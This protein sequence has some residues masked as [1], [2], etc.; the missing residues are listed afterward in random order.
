MLPRDLKTNDDRGDLHQKADMSVK[1]ERW[2][3][4][5]GTVSE[6]LVEIT[7]TLVFEI[8]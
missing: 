5:V 3:P 2:V 4:G 7:K 8:Q 6:V 1:Y